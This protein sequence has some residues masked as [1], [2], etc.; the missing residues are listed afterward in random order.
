MLQNIE[1]KEGVVEIKQT[2]PRSVKKCIEFMYTGK[3][4][5]ADEHQEELLHT[6]HML[7]LHSKLHRILCHVVYR[8]TTYQT[9]EVLNLLGK[10]ALS[11]LF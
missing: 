6:A 10:S 4:T 3:A 2:R 9:S 1:N 5:V 7:R 8:M 11:L